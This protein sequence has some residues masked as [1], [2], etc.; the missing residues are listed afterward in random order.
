VVVKMLSSRYKHL[1]MS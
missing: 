1:L